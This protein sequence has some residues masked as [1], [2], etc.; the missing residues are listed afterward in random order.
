M[1]HLDLDVYVLTPWHQ[2]SLLSTFYLLHKSHQQHTCVRLN[3][4][5]ED[6]NIVNIC[7]PKRWEG[8]PPSRTFLRSLVLSGRTATLHCHSTSFFRENYQQVALKA[9]I[10]WMN[11]SYTLPTT[12]I[13]PENRP[14]QKEIS[15]S[16]QQRSGTMLVSGRVFENDAMQKR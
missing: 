2:T 11:I 5:S 3:Y 8:A 10:L 13:S 16:N 14:S 1:N 12:N 9:Y 7:T 6:I 4:P 15:S